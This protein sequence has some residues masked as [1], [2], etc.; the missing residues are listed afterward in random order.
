MG[1]PAIVEPIPVPLPD[2]ELLA[3]LFRGLGDAARLRILELLLGGPRTQKEIVSEIGLSQG[4]ISQHLSCPAWCGFVDARREGR[5]VR[6]SIASPRVAALID[7]GEGLLA[8]TRGDIGSCR[9]V[10]D[11]G[12]IDE[13]R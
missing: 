1:C 5:T 12:N 8:S 2:E 6:C 3:R 7:L 13:S 4:R 11:P 10:H 9:I